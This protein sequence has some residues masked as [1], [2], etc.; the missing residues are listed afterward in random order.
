MPADQLRDGR[1]ALVLRVLQGGAAALGAVANSF[2]MIDS[3][4]I[5]VGGV[6]TDDLTGLTRAQDSTADVEHADWVKAYRLPATT[7]SDAGV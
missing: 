3:E 1:V 5:K 4:I 2:I 6:S 7:V